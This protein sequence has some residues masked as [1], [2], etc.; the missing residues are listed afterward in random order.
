MRIQHGNCQVLV[1]DVQTKLAPHL[2]NQVSLTKNI[3]ALLQAADIFTIPTTF[4]QQYTSGLGDT[5]APLTPYIHDNVYE[6]NSFSCFGNPLHTE[7]LAKYAAEGRN[8]LI[9]VGCEAHVCVLQTVIDAL[10]QGYRVVVV[11]DGVG[12]RKASDWQLAQERLVGLGA[13]YVSLEMLLFEWLETKDAPAFK[14]ILNL[15]K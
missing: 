8:T 6:K 9:V 3:T 1:V 11:Q 5:I 12:S 7:Q 15:V 4:A 10:V 14:Q 13:E 2:F